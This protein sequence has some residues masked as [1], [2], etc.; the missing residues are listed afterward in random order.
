MVL[1]LDENGWAS[2]K[3]LIEKVSHHSMKL[4]MEML[5]YVVETNNKKRFTF[6]HDKTKIPDSQGRDLTI[7]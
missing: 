4:D 3:E 2:V 5:E 1:V 7:L 6:N